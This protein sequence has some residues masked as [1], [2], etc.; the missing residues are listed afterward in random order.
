MP[1]RER[2]ETRKNTG[3]LKAETARTKMDAESLVQKGE[4]PEPGRR[5][6]RP[7]AVV[8]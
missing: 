4:T 2:P 1:E 6:G 5:G 3:R 7:R 8:P